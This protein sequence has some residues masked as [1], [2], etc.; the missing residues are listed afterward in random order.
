MKVS[1][2][3]QNYHNSLIGQDK[4]KP[5]GVKCAFNLHLGW[6]ENEE[7]VPQILENVKYIILATWRPKL[8]AWHFSTVFLFSES[9]PVGV[10]IRISKLWHNCLVE[11]KWSSFPFPLIKL[12][13]KSVSFSC[14]G[15]ACTGPVNE[16][17]PRSWHT[18]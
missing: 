2:C 1:H 6:D 18:F 7:S 17:M 3:E 9:C 12:L 13:N 11:G 16:T 8:K 14:T 5:S 10:T 15:L 4:N